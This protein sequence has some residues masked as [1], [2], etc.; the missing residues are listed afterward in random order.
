LS[1]GL[2]T[3][4]VPKATNGGSSYINE[5]TGNI[6]APNNSTSRPFL[7]ASWTSF[8]ETDRSD[9]ISL[10]GKPLIRLTPEAWS[11]ESERTESRVT[12]GNIIPS[13]GGVTSSSARRDSQKRVV[14]LLNE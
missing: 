8:I 3:A 12:P 4:A 1:T 10:S 5:F 11:R 9:T 7:E 2:I 6:P 14:E 13:N